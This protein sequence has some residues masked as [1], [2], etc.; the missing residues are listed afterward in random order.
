MRVVLKPGGL[1]VILGTIL[2]LAAI[3]YAGWQKAQT[4]A[5]FGNKPTLG[6][7][8][9]SLGVV[10]QPRDGELVAPDTQIWRVRAVYPASADINS[11]VAQPAP[12]KGDAHAMRLTI[13]AL[14]PGKGIA[15][16][17]ITKNVPV[18]VAK[19]T[20]VSVEFWARSTSNAPMETALALDDITELKE[21]GVLSQDWKKFFYTGTVQHDYA[22]GLL[23]LA[24]RFGEQTGDVEVAQ[25]RLKSL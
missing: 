1:L 8:A 23:Q 9:A 15:G 12:W 3:A 18:A 6:E 17:S 5:I 22:P 25:V 14:D 16:V 20:R 2:A 21:S 11:V 10:Q 4:M 7:K 13:A 19:G 24:L